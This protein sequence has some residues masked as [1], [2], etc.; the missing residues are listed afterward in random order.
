MQ[1]LASMIMTTVILTVVVA[2]RRQR[3]DGRKELG[4]DIRIKKISDY[5]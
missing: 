5:D 1:I 3:F 2:Q 4:T